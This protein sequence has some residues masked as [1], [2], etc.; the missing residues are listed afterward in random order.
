MVQERL[1]PVVREEIG[2]LAQSHQRVI[3]NL[4]MVRIE[5]GVR[6]YRG[7]VGR[8]YKARGTLARAFVAK[9]ALDL[10][11][12][13]QLLDR[14][15]G[16]PG[17]CIEAGMQGRLLAVILGQVIHDLRNVFTLDR[18]AHHFNHFVD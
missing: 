6:S 4:E 13:R 15:I 5:E 12:T 1:F 18:R 9:A 3:A 16:G 14:Q 8:P 10:P 2:P 11:T 17:V 7:F